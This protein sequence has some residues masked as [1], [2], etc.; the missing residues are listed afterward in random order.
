MVDPV[1]VPSTVPGSSPVVPSFGGAKHPALHHSQ[2]LIFTPRAHT[3]LDAG[4]LLGQGGQV[5]MQI[6]TRVSHFTG[7]V[8]SSPPTPTSA[9]ASPPNVSRV[10]SPGG[11]TG[12]RHHGGGG[13]SSNNNGSAGI[14]TTYTTYYRSSSPSSPV[15]N[16]L[17]TPHQSNHSHSSSSLGQGYRDPRTS[18]RAFFSIACPSASGTSMT[19]F[20]SVPDDFAIDGSWGWR[21]SACV[22]IPME[23]P[24]VAAS[25]GNTVSAG[26][27]ATRARAST[28]DGSWARV[29]ESAGVQQW[30]RELTSV[31][32]MVVIGVV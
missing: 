20:R 25:S 1:P 21:S 7:A 18:V 4:G 28:V 26:L 13:I 11:V 32:A 29:S 24:T 9:L 14:S 17:Y 8:S 30:L 15:S 10:T 6:S 19:V 27:S 12:N 22:E 16:S 31:R 5:P 3:P 23:S 2:S